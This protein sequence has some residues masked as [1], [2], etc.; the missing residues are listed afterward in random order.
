MAIK[1]NCSN[2][3]VRDRLKR[4]EFIIDHIG[5]GDVIA[6]RDWVDTA[7]KACIRQLTN[8][9]IIIVLNPSDRKVVT[10]WT[11]SVLQVRA[12]YHGKMIPNWMY[13][14]IKKNEEIMKKFHE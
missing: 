11:A 5:F 2:H 3:L 9:G 6:E 8:T 7:G 14:R 4:V 1:K 10:M 13:H 12:M